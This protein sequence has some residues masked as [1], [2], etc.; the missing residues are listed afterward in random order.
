MSMGQV[1]QIGTPNEIYSDPNNTFVA[2]FIGNPPMNFFP[3]TIENGTF[4]GKGFSVKLSE[5]NAALAKGYDGNGKP[6]IL[7]I[8]PES[9]IVGKVHPFTV[10]LVEHLGQNSLVHGSLEGDNKC[11][12]KLPGWQRLEK[13]DSIKVE[14]RQEKV[15]LF[16]GESNDRI[17]KVK[18]GKEEA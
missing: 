15:C 12:L 7:A 3:G 8:R 5:E 14:F 16:D 13:G 11:I 4:I 18:T 2:S 10:D 17:R 9:F 6:I 1:Q